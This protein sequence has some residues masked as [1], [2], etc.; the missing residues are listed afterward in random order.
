VSN[1]EW[2][3][4][5]NTVFEK[6]WTRHNLQSTEYLIQT[7]NQIS[8]KFQM[9]CCCVE[10][11]QKSLSYFVLVVFKGPKALRSNYNINQSQIKK[12]KENW[13]V[14]QEYYAESWDEE[15]V[16]WVLKL[17]FLGCLQQSQWTEAF[18]QTVLSI[19]RFPD[20]DQNTEE[21][22]DIEILCRSKM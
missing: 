5:W 15:S 22:R 19:V 10:Y 7:N 16:E 18:L 9:N 14:I 21:K 1:W 17:Q 4:L 3:I 2:E 11:Q 6:V 20:H 8:C 12:R 13:S